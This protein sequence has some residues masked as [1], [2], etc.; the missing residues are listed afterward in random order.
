[1]N[2]KVRRLSLYTIN[3]KIPRSSNEFCA[4]CSLHTTVRTCVRERNSRSTF[5]EPAALRYCDALVLSSTHLNSLKLEIQR[6]INRRDVN[7]DVKYALLHAERGSLSHPFS[8]PPPP[9]PLSLSL[10]LS[11]P[12]FL[13]CRL[14]YPTPMLPRALSLS[15]RLRLPRERNRILSFNSTISCC[16]SLPPHSSFSF[17]IP[18]PSASE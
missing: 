11:S 4:K 1:M 8:P 3:D 9:P 15:S 2:I 12:P 17:S 7:C 5:R 18:R 10:S 6:R 14:Y 13:A 16:L